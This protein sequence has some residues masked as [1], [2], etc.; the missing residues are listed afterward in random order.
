MSAPSVVVI[1]DD[2]TVVMLLEHALAV[3]GYR[4]IGAGGTQEGVA[5]IRTRQPDLVVVDAPY[6]PAGTDWYILAFTGQ[7]GETHQAYTVPIPLQL[8]DFYTTLSEAL[9]GS[10]LPPPMERSRGGDMQ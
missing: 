7:D 8:E 4:V 3:E 6:A 2:P 9:R 1:N 5:A 10:G